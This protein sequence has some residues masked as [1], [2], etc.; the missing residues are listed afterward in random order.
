MKEFLSIAI[1]CGLAGMFVGVAL[2][3]LLHRRGL[4]LA[5]FR[6]YRKG[7][8]HGLGIVREMPGPKAEDKPCRA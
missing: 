4:R 8:Q 1:P 6:G 5:E 2:M 7:Y 3:A